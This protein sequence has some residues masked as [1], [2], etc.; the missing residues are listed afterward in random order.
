[1]IVGAGLAVLGSALAVAGRRQSDTPWIRVDHRLRERRRA[2]NA[3][4]V[5][6]DLVGY[7]LLSDRLGFFLVAPAFL[8]VLLWAFGTRPRWILPI[9]I[10]VPALVHYGF[11]T[12]LHVPLPWGLLERFAW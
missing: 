6:A 7:A 8:A 9:A 1:M 2:L 12:L 11:Y 3:V 10:V 5:V 4:L